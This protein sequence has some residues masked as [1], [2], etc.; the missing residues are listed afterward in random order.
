[1]AWP[2]STTMSALSVT[3]KAKTSAGGTNPPAAVWFPPSARAGGMRPRAPSF[4]AT[5]NAGSFQ[6]L[7]F[8][9]FHHAHILEKHACR[10][11]MSRFGLAFG[12]AA[13]LGA[14]VAGNCNPGDLPMLHYLGAA[15]SFMS[16][17]FFTSILTA[18]TRLCV[19]SGYER[20]LY[21]LR[22]VSAVLQIVLTIGYAVL[23]VQV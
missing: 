11:L 10:S 8:C 5:I 15:L 17:C 22:T 18:L 7:L 3:G 13:A 6:F 19:L 21:P 23:F 16:I 9:I 1:M 14:F 2:A 12:L 20:I 4:S